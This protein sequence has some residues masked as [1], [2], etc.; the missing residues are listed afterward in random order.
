M[1]LSCRSIALASVSVKASDVLDV[2]TGCFHWFCLMCK[3]YAV[4]LVVVAASYSI[5]SVVREVRSV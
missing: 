2:C 1:L 4:S 3:G 5:V